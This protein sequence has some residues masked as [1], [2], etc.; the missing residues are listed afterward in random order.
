M[1][2][3]DLFKSTSPVIHRPVASY[4]ES[5]PEKKVQELLHKLIYGK[6]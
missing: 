2:I 1:E 3:L 5:T 4:F 6:K